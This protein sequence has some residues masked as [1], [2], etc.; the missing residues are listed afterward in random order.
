MN[1]S[2]R[3]IGKGDA[4]ECH[5]HNAVVSPE[6]GCRVAFADGWLRADCVSLWNASF[7][8][9]KVVELYMYM[10]L[11]SGNMKVVY[12][13]SRELPVF[14]HAAWKLGW[15]IW[16]GPR[17]HCEMSISREICSRLFR[18]ESEIRPRAIGIHRQGEKNKEQGASHCDGDGDCDKKQSLYTNTRHS[19][20]PPPS[21]RYALFEEVNRC[22]CASALPDGHAPWLNQLVPDHMW[23]IRATSIFSFQDG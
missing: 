21:S 2:D 22:L 14:V 20:P 15:G 3:H 16:T 9:T 7:G 10:G 4:R 17:S 23:H 1:L 18:I 8:L 12:A 19:K 13:Y 5:R 6:L 11:R